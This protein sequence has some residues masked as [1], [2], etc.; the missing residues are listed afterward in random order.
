MP[1]ELAN[2]TAGTGPEKEVS[3]VSFFFFSRVCASCAQTPLVINRLFTYF[4]DRF[5][6]CKFF[7]CDTV[8]L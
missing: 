5:K 8:V 7:Y 3:G 1:I 4:S 2:I 6:F